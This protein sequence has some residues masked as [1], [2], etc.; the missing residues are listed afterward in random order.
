MLS[1]PGIKCLLLQL[2]F[3][4]HPL[5]L[6]LIT[7]I[8]LANRSEVHSHSQAQA[9]P[10]QTS[11]QRKEEMTERK[12]N[13]VAKRESACLSPDQ[14]VCQSRLTDRLAAGRSTGR[15]LRDP[16]PRSAFRRFAGDVRLLEEAAAE[17]KTRDSYFNRYY[18]SPISCHI[19]LARHS[20]G[21]AVAS[22][23]VVLVWNFSF[24]TK[25]SI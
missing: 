19:S 8:A 10:P 13:R 20:E 22:A 25:I 7:V 5:Q 3:A 6:I 11:K 12:T 15:N 4:K 24:I 1:N 17:R 16:R 9:M 21:E 18:S 2:F 23:H 14:T